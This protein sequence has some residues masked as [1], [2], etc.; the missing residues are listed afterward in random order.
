MTLKIEKANLPK[1]EN[2]F[3]AK[4]R[5]LQSDYRDNVLKEPYGHGPN[6][7]SETKY[8]NMLIDGKKTGSNFISNSA[9]SYAKQKA[10][11]KQI[12]K[13]LTIEEY[14][15][16]NNM[17]SSMPMCFNLF[18]DLRELLL[19]DKDEVSRIVKLMFK[20]IKWID[21]VTYID[22][23]FI[24][25]PIK[26]YTNDKSAFDA[27]ILVQDEKGKKGLISI[28]TKYTDLLGSNKASR[29]VIKEG[30]IENNKIF[31]DEL[32]KELKD[33]K[34]G[35]KQI[36]RNYLLTYAFA[37]KNK[38][39]H[40]TNVVVSPSGDSL[41]VKEIEKFK[42]HLLQ[43]EDTIMKI[44]LELIVERGINCNSKSISTIMK[45]FKERY[46]I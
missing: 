5:K 32:V 3:T 12:N 9:F 21:K 37:K 17:L 42:S 14:R 25:T 23:E 33:I 10:L 41:S 15:L 2:P 19:T 43:K 1:N 4:Y 18:S 40:F 38:F 16:F 11:D 22:V 44:P 36:H 24:P 27:M 7:N 13:D 39:K 31:D 34:H 26:D 45:I 46:L 28:E 30:L 35:F 20:E 29:S 8:G 6:K